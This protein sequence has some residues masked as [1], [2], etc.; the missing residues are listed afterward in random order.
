MTPI[1]RNDRF[2]AAAGTPPTIG[3]PE[4]PKNLPLLQAPDPLAPDR[5][6]PR[7]IAPRTIVMAELDPAVRTDLLAAAARDIRI[8]PRGL[9]QLGVA[10]RG[11]AKP[12]RSHTRTLR[13]DRTRSRSGSRCQRPSASCQLRPSVLPSGGHVVSPPVAIGS[14]RRAVVAKPSRYRGRPVLSCGRRVAP[15]A[16][17]DL[18]VGGL[19]A[20]VAVAT[21]RTSQ[22]RR[23]RDVAVRGPQRSAPLPTGACRGC[24]TSAPTSARV[25]P[26][27]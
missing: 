16:A 27:L 9:R 13:R 14:P 11:A 6:A 26:S 19:L 20:S 23:R 10:A 18:R 1:V 15:T 17:S 24:R 25:K 22:L 2:V 3:L 12:L 8:G 4:P 5:P 7:G 21:I